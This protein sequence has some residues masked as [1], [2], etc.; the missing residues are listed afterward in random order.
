MKVT[1]FLDPTVYSTYVSKVL[2]N[3]DFFVLL[4]YSNGYYS[5]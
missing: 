3:L 5:T 2:L 1:Y 4:H